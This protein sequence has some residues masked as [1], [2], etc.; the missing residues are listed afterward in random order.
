VRRIPINVGL[1]L[2]ALI[3]VAMLASLRWSF[4][5]RWCSTEGDGF[6]L[7][8]IILD[9]GALG[10][11]SEPPFPYELRAP[12]VDWLVRRSQ[13]PFHWG[14]YWLNDPRL[15]RVTLPLWIPLGIATM[16]TGGLWYTDVRRRRRGGCSLC[17]Y[18]VRGLSPEAWARCPECG[19][20]PATR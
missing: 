12:G 11:A 20:R 1:G 14:A 4:Q 17:G 2:C 10:Y 13:A 9:G 3:V 5:C 6:A 16:A 18:D 7:C 8:A 15:V 19:R